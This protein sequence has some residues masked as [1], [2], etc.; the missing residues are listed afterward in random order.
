MWH[1][2]L[3]VLYEIPRCQGSVTPGQAVFEQHAQGVLDWHADDTPAPLDSSSWGRPFLLG[4][5][6][7]T[8]RHWRIGAHIFPTCILAFLSTSAGHLHLCGALACAKICMATAHSLVQEL[9]I[10]AELECGCAQNFH[11]HF[12][13]KTST[14]ILALKRMTWGGACTCHNLQGYTRLP[15]W[16]KNSGHVQM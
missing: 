8:C 4:R 14:C 3:K 7:G 1:D 11:R 12:A 15:L 6:R 9:R 2:T 13:R 16:L 5:V 10:R